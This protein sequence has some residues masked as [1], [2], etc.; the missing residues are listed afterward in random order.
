MAAVGFDGSG[1]SCVVASVTDG[2]HGEG[3]A[4]DT[5]SSSVAFAAP[6]VV[7]A[8]VVAVAVALAVGH[9]ER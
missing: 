4:G 8:P 3:E 5:T 9:R 1:S 2:E 7:A 6:V